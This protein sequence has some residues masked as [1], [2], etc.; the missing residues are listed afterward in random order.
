[1]PKAAPSNP[2]PAR[3][4]I[5][6]SPYTGTFSTDVEVGWGTEKVLVADPEWTFFDEYGHFH[7]VDT[8]GGGFPTLIARTER[9]ACDG[10]CGNEDGCGGHAVTRYSCQL[11]AES[12]EPRY[13]TVTR[14]FETGRVYSWS[15]TVHGA[16]IV[17]GIAVSVIINEEGMAPRFGVAVI[18]RIALESKGPFELGLVGSGRLGFRPA[19]KSTKE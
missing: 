6:K 3:F 17:P 2:K 15:A 8:L 4:L 5:N 7:A 14:Q 18:A 13:K 10:S 11:C 16:Y 19:E 1:M 9:A 12:I